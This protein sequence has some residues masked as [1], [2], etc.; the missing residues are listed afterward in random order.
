M[1]EVL[2]LDFQ[3]D[4]IRALPDHLPKN[5]L[6]DCVLMQFTGIKDKNGKEI[7]EEDLVTIRYGLDEG[8]HEATCVI[9]WHNFLAAFVAFDTRTVLPRHEPLHHEVEI[10]GNIYENPQLLT[11]PSAS[12]SPER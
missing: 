9:R 4:A 11:Q 2:E 1:S 7:F 6:S 10:I 3:H 8:V 5:R 12:Q